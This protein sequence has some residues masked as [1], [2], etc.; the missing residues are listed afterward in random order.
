MS[1]TFVPGTDSLVIKDT[2]RVYG[3]S[4][5]AML[6]LFIVLR[7]RNPKLFSIRQW[8]PKIRCELAQQDFGFISWIWK[9]YSPTEEDILDQCGMD[10][11][12]FLRVLRFGIKLSCVGIFNSIWLLPMYA[13]AKTSRETVRIDDP[14][15]EMTTSNLPSLSPRFIGTVLGAYIVFLYSMFLILHEYEWFTKWRHVFL[16]KRTPRNYAI[17]VS[18]IPKEYRSSKLLLEYFRSCFPHDMVLEAHLALDIPNL[19]KQV[20]H[21]VTVVAKL[22]HSMAIKQIYGQ[23]PT[24][25]NIKGKVDSVSSYTKE[26]RHLNNSIR[27]KIENIDDL[28]ER[29]KKTSMPCIYGESISMNIPHA[30]S[31]QSYNESELQSSQRINHHRDCIIDLYPELG[32]RKRTFR[33]RLNIFGQPEDREQDQLSDSDDDE[34]SSHE[35]S[36]ELQH[37]RDFMVEPHS[38]FRLDHVESSYQ[39]KILRS[40]T[41]LEQGIKETSEAFS[42]QSNFFSPS[43]F[44]M[45]KPNPFYHNSLTSTSVP[46]ATK[47]ISVWD[48]RSS[49][50]IHQYPSKWRQRTQAEKTLL[51]EQSIHGNDSRMLQA[52]SYENGDSCHHQYQ[53]RFSS[54][55]L[56]SSFMST[57]VTSNRECYECHSD[58][59]SKYDNKDLL[60]LSQNQFKGDAIQENFDSRLPPFHIHNYEKSLKSFQSHHDSDSVNNLSKRI[61]VTAKALSAKVVKSITGSSTDT[62]IREVEKAVKEVNIESVRSIT[63][64]G[65]QKLKKESTKGMRQMATVG[66]VAIQDVVHSAKEILIGNQDGKARDAG[67]VVFRNLSTTHAALQMIHNGSPYIMNVESA[68]EPHDIYWEIVGKSHSSKIMGKVISFALSA[69]LCLFWTVPVSVISGFS[70]VDNLKSSIPFLAVM[71]EKQPWLEQ[72]L[73]QIAPLLLILLNLQLPLLLRKFATLEGYIASSSLEASLFLKLSVFMIIQTFFVSAI[74]GGVY[75]RLT[76]IL[77]DPAAI[78]DL[79]ANSLPTR[80]TYFVQLMLVKTFVGQGVALLRLVPLSLAFLKSKLGPNLT[81]KERERAYGVYLRPLSDPREFE[82]AQELANLVLY[83]MVI[84]VYAVISPVINYFVLICL[85]IMSTSYRYQFILNFPSTP[86]SGGMLWY[87]FISICMTCMV[88]A[89][90]TLVGLLALK[91]ATYSL[92]CMAPLLSITVAFALYLRGRHSDVTKHLPTKDCIQLDKEYITQKNEDFSFVENKYIQPTLLAKDIF[93]EDIEIEIPSIR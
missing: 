7:K 55:F 3:T 43:I 85:I 23:S 19:C 13:T 37:F 67:F 57:T 49:N 56:L 68:P 77:R 61:H 11:L 86:D 72:A 50:D 35:S 62:I 1:D 60:I 41:C 40:T 34:Y 39:K 15:E 25:I 22:E 66:S 44:R 20:A 82:H 80:G 53:E 2:F 21:R 16:S 91:K 74:S 75:A 73:S 30:Q 90:I 88:I 31:C 76:Q 52:S 14:V 4:F 63:K 26:L 69:T 78:I 83:F 28:I 89:Q 9:V 33:E 27:K 59:D 87:D 17:Y 71:I 18:G 54:S 84:Y 65:V 45:I 58:G 42:E 36:H 32:I 93:P 70:E 51:E 8:S 64:L 81:K 48:Y 92:P 46:F 12:C 38:P 79:L 6:L 10:A 47:D 24:H 5:A 29:M